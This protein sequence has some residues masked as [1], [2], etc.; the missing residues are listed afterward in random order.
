MWYNRYGFGGSGRGRFRFYGGGPWFWFGHFPPIEE[1][2]KWLEEYR[3]HLKDELDEIE[4]RIER[5]RGERK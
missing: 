1:E 5:L 4:R 3:T 2:L